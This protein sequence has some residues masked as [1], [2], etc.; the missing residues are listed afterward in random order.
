MIEYSIKIRHSKE[1]KSWQASVIKFSGLHPKAVLNTPSHDS[2]SG[3]FGEIAAWIGHGDG[4]SKAA[5]CSSLSSEPLGSP[6]ECGKRFQMTWIDGTPHDFVCGKPSGHDNSVKCQEGLMRYAGPTL[7]GPHFEHGNARQYVAYRDSCPCTEDE[8]LRGDC[9]REGCGHCSARVSNPASLL[10]LEQ[11]RDK[12]QCASCKEYGGIV[13][14][15]C[16][17]CEKAAQLLG[18]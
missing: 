18:H 15:L 2:I 13:D 14:G 8:N 7:K 12:F 9:A 16:E 6:R 1:D 17:K 4:K 5:E 11:E 10:K 3:V